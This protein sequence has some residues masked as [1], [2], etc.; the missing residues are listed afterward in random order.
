MLCLNVDR[1]MNVLLFRS[2]TGLKQ[3]DLTSGLVTVTTLLAQS[4]AAL[5]G[6]LERLEHIAADQG[7]AGDAAGGPGGMVLVL[8]DD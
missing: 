4:R 2:R 5:G 1:D 8:P 3:V 7:R 6:R